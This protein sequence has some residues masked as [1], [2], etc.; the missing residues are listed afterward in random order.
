MRRAATSAGRKCG[1]WWWVSEGSR[2]WEQHSRP[3]QPQTRLCPCCCVF[4]LSHLTPPCLTPHL[5]RSAGTQAMIPA[6]AVVRKSRTPDG[7]KAWNLVLSW[8]WIR[9]VM[10][11]SAAWP[12]FLEAPGEVL[13]PPLQ[14]LV[15]CGEP[16]ACVRVTPNFCHHGAWILR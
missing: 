2:R 14:L 13:P 8:L 3:A 12:C 16:L 5:K 15:V 4:W 1:S 6:R 9:P 10:R 11:L 7:L